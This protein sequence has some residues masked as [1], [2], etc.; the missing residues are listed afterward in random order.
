MEKFRNYFGTWNMNK[1]ERD[2]KVLLIKNEKYK[3]CLICEELGKE[4]DNYHLHFVL[5]LRTQCTLSS[6]RKH[7]KGS[8]IER[9]VN[10]N[11]CIKY[12]K[13]DGNIIFEDGEIKQ[14][15]RTDLMRIR[16]AV[17]AGNES[18]RNLID[19]C[20]NYQAVKLA[21][22]LIKFKG[23][24]RNWKPIVRW[25]WGPT[26]AGKTKLAVDEA[27]PFFWISDR[28]LDWFEAYDGEENVILDDFRGDCIKLHTLLR[29]LDRYP[30]RVNYKGGSREFLAKNIWITSCKSPEDAYP[31][32]SEDI[33][34]LIRRIDLIKYMPGV[35]PSD[36]Q[37]LG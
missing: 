11:D 34:Q 8:H 13:K 29:L 35:P 12:T 31:N 25:Y 23:Q 27:R 7:L 16:E 6:I 5:C 21:E 28:N 19:L 15:K 2:D 30:M 32:C 10:V 20:P 9:C 37:K 14:G 26:G 4:T 22:T 24:R 36:A 18:M 33:A 17:T 3:Y 1:D